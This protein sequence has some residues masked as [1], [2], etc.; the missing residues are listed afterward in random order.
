MQEQLNEVVRESDSSGI[1]N[2]AQLNKSKGKAMDIFKKSSIG[3]H[4]LLAGDVKD[5]QAC[6]QN[7]A[8]RVVMLW[9]HKAPRNNTYKIPNSPHL[10]IG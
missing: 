4:A 6:A 5:L 1:T 10:I 2:L 3:S 7:F 8:D 9:S